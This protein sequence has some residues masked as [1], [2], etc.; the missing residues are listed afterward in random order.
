M[1]RIQV[2]GRD[3]VPDEARTAYDAAVGY[4]PFASLAGAMARRPPILNNVFGMLGDLRDDGLLD[5]R[6]LE[7]AL[8]AVSRLNAC[9]YCVAHHSP[10]LNVA[11][12]SGE[13]IANI[14]D[15]ETVAEFDAK[16][17]LVIEYA[18]A[19]TLDA[20]RVRDG[21]FERLREHFTE[22]EIVELTWR[23][24]LCGAFNRF[25]D[26]LQLDIEDDAHA[27]MENVA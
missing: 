5:R 15:Y 17:R 4:G 22:P 16:D 1:A 11:G 14:L 25:N 24:A 10:M 7:L 18:K 6:S 19:V 12:V 8:V 23:I 20:N 21:M 27:A 13:A 3:D 26:V 9:D 2:H